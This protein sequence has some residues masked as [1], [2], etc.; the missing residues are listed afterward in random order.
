[1]T[2]ADSCFD[3][4]ID[5]GDSSEKEDVEA[6]PKELIIWFTDITGNSNKNLSHFLG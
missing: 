2:D 3:I 5:L 1:M 6:I 4:D